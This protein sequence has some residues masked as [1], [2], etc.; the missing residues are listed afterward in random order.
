MGSLLHFLN[1]VL[2]LINELVT[3]HKAGERDKAEQA[4]KENPREFFNQGNPSNKPDDSSDSLSDD[5]KH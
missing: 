1:L 5:S 3:R 2:S 4:I